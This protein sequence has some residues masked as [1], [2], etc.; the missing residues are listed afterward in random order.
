MAGR[1][2]ASLKMTDNSHQRNQF[3]WAYAVRR[4]QQVPD[5]FC[6][7]HLPAEDAHRRMQ[8][9]SPNHLVRGLQF[10]VGG[11]RLNRFQETR[12]LAAVS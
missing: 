7:R 1:V 5:V 9:T 12:E 11:V 3:V 4:T 6:I 8:S 2:N 10:L